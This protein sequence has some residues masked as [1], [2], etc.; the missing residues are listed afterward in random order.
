MYCAQATKTLQMPS[1][2][3]Y[4]SIKCNTLEWGHRLEI[5]EWFEYVVY[6]KWYTPCYTICCNFHGNAPF[7]QRI[8]LKWCFSQVNS[9]TIINRT[10]YHEN[11]SSLIYKLNKYLYVKCTFAIFNEMKSIYHC[12]I[13]RGTFSEFIAR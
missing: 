5:D 11:W 8:L 1:I 3:N 12:K 6:N 9:Q 10:I 2:W 7:E 13:F 4:N